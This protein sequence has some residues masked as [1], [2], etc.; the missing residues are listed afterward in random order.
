[1]SAATVTSPSGWTYRDD[2]QNGDGVSCAMC[3]DLLNDDLPIV[4]DGEGYAYHEVCADDDHLG[5]ERTTDELLRHLDIGH[6]V[7][8]NTVEPGDEESLH[9]QMHDEEGDR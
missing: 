9:E 8:P 3:G 6:G 2:Q 7:D 1:M 4:N 5:V